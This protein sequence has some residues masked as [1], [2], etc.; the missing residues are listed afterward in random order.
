MNEWVNEWISWLLCVYLADSRFNHIHITLNNY[1]SFWYENQKQ[2]KL[3]DTELL[4]LLLCI[5]S[6]YHRMKKTKHKILMLAIQTCNHIK[7]NKF[8]CIMILLFG[9]LVI[10]FVHVILITVKKKPLGHFSFCAII[11]KMY[12]LNGIVCARARCAYSQTNRLWL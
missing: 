6:A 4:W 3:T 5:V 11:A 8:V 7:W 9:A 1:T 10:P 12:M 2:N